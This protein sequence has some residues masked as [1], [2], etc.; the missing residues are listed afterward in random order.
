MDIRSTAKRIAFSKRSLNKVAI[1]S[2]GYLFFVLQYVTCDH[3]SF[4]L[5]QP[6]KHRHRSLHLDSHS[7]SFFLR[8]HHPLLARI[9]FSIKLPVAQRAQRASK[10]LNCAS[11]KAT[12][13]ISRYV[14]NFINI[15]NNFNDGSIISIMNFDDD[16]TMLLDLVNFAN[17]HI[18]HSLF[19]DA[20]YLPPPSSLSHNSI[21]S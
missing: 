1:N 13:Y 7:R 6:R 12:T 21:V 2:Y 18:A 11:Q 20:V 10:I 14:R 9:D 16:P 4:I 17:S 5:L 3:Y 19:P 15:I 8:R